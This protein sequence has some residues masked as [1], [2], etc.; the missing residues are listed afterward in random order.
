MDH[1]GQWGRRSSIR[2]DGPH[3]YAALTPDNAY[4]FDI[5]LQTITFDD[6]PANLS[7]E[8]SGPTKSTY[9]SSIQNRVVLGASVTMPSSVR[10]GRCRPVGLFG[11]TRTTQSY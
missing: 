10:L 8:C 6:A 3:R 5:D 11:F 9:V 1:G 4:A 7:S 2:A